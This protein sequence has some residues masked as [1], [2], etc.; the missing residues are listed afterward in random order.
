VNWW[1]LGLF[2][3]LRLCDLVLS[4]RADTIQLLLLSQLLLWHGE[5]SIRGSRKMSS[6]T[7]HHRRRT[8]QIPASSE[9]HHRLPRLFS[10]TGYSLRATGPSN[11]EESEDHL[12]NESALSSDDDS[13][14]RQRH[15]T[16]SSFLASAARTYS[17]AMYAH[18]T[19][20]IPIPGTTTLPSYTR[21]MHAFTLNQLN[22]MDNTSSHN[23]RTRR[24][25]QRRQ[26]KKA[27]EVPNN[28][29][30]SHIQASSPLALKLPPSQTGSKYL[31]R[32]LATLNQMS[33]DEEPCGPSNTPEPSGMAL[34]PAPT[35]MPEPLLASSS[36][37]V[38][39]LAHGRELEARFEELMA[40]VSADGIGV[41]NLAEARDFAAVGL[42]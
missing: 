23:P 6:H 42:V 4:A 20:Q 21:T 41:F 12:D 36:S 9:T 29:H 30:K 17:R 32:S 3:L 34:A 15:S 24:E 19:S 26:Q 38:D 27:V 2:G 37:S 35:S 25:Q 39:V 7:R 33:L 18:T 8:T 1:L 13:E 28:S 40:G 31:S 16:G 10:S 5:F 22:H 11:N 14:R